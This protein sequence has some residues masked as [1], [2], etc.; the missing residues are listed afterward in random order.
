MGWGESI[1]L[2]IETDY[3]D[4][5]MTNPRVLRMELRGPSSGENHALLERWSR[6]QPIH[7][8]SPVFSLDFVNNRE[9]DELQAEDP[10]TMRG[11]DP[12][13]DTPIEADAN[14]RVDLP[15][16]APPPGSVDPVVARRSVATGPLNMAIDLVTL[17]AGTMKLRQRP[18]DIET[19]SIS[20]VDGV[21]AYYEQNRFHAGTVDIWL[22]PLAPGGQ[23]YPD[24][25]DILPGPDG[26]EPDRVHIDTRHTILS[27]CRSA[28]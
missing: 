10:V 23:A 26:P 3:I 24:R 27:G 7:M 4:D 2:D 28:A 25:I 6:G 16:P 22:S 19:P 14:G 1:V 21:L 20:L 13:R 12:L 9:L 17:S 8:R 11:L 5:S 15:A 18:A